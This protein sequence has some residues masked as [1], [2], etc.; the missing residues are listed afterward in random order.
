MTRPGPHN[1]ITDV[2]GVCVGHHTLTDDRSL[3]GVTV[4]VPPKGTTA[5]VD[6]RGAAPGT[7]ETDLL[8][9]VNLVDA[10]DAVVLS[11]G[12]AYGLATADGV[13]AALEEDGRGWPIAGGVVPIVP[14]AVV[15][16]L[17]RGGD[18]TARPGAAH[19]RAAY[20]AASSDP[21][22]LG[23]VGAGTGALAGALRGG[24][25]SASAVL[26]SGATVAALVVANPVG[27]VVDPRTGELFSAR[28]ATAADDLPG[29]PAQDEARTAYQQLL[30]ERREA[31]EIGAATSIGVVV[32]DLTLTKAQCRKLAAIGH[33]GLARAIDPVHTMFDGDTIFGLATGERGAP[34]PVELFDLLEAAATCVTR[35]V[36][37]A[38]V[39]AEPDG[40]APAYRQV[41]G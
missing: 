25:G 28:F 27:S 40:P 7:R 8:D 23:S 13:M 35:A 20:A 15:F 30:R 17:G 10:V 39:R 18:I 21:V 4:V 6:V 36:G 19:G 26:P 41:F 2:A 31:F 11:G 33:D 16:D 12:S 5:G 3:T 24:V 34:N 32:T 29:G 22:P 9:P 38:V 14:A 1:D 37:R